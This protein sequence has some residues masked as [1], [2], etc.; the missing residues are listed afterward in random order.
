MTDGILR[1]INT[2][3]KLYK[4]LIQADI[5]NEPLYNVL[6]DN[7]STYRAILRRS[8]RHAK[9]LYY[10]KTFNMFKNDNK[11]TWSVIKD[12]FKNASNRD[13]PNMFVIENQ[14]I[15]NPAVIAEKFNDYF[16]RSV[17]HFQIT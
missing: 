17:N 5:Q 3:D 14:T 16:I 4:I 8:I 6:K 10:A 12:S 7:Y 15:H 13:L 11:K 1:S 9:K 2:K